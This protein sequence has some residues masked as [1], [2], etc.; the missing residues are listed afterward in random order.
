MRALQV[1]QRA[2]DLEPQV[3]EGRQL[4]RGESFGGHQSRALLDEESRRDILMSAAM[5][6]IGHD[7]SM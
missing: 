1:A 3:V 6:V 5:R 2:A 7:R 4:D